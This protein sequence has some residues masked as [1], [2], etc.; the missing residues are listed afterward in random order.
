MS[1]TSV[2]ILGQLV[3]MSSDNGIRII[4]YTNQYSYP[5]AHIFFSINH[6]S[7]ALLFNGH[8]LY[9]TNFTDQY[10]SPFRLCYFD[11]ILDFE[12]EIEIKHELRQSVV[13]LY[14][15]PDVKLYQI[16]I[17]SKI[18]SISCCAKLNMIMLLSEAGIHFFDE[19]MDCIRYVSINALY[20]CS[21]DGAK[22]ALVQNT[23]EGKVVFFGDLNNF[24]SLED[25]K[26]ATRKV[27]LFMYAPFM[28]NKEKHHTT[29]YSIVMYR[30][31]TQVLYVLAGDEIITK[32]SVNI[33]N[34]NDILF[35]KCSE[36]RDNTITMFIG[37]SNSLTRILMKQNRKCD[38]KQFP[39]NR[40]NSKYDCE[41]VSIPEQNKD[42]FVVFGGR[43]QKIYSYAKDSAEMKLEFETQIGR[44]E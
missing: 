33:G 32:F 14:K 18:I 4:K 36:G 44:L 24:K 12:K 43:T 3:V 8:L 38:V 16:P 31:Q 42:Y 34:L 30:N 7:Q 21:L 40:V 23:N 39:F 1:I 29:N 6:V 27:I 28:G 17:N 37:M 20:M 9:I 11:P 26:P 35:A 10:S 25:S 22:I 41:F 15:V 13:K 2:Q 19:D 5:I